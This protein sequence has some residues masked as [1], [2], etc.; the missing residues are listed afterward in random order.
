M[1]RIRADAEQTSA[2][3]VPI[4]LH[5]RHRVEGQTVFWSL[6]PQFPGKLDEDSGDTVRYLPPAA[7]SIS[8]PA[9]ITII[10]T[11]GNAR[12]SIELALQPWPVSVPM[13]T[14][15]DAYVGQCNMWAWSILMQRSMMT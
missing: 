15:A 7:G 10:A 14:R 3:G 5:A 1:L 4:T 11:V 13:L 9:T 2:G 8:A 12:Q 6:D